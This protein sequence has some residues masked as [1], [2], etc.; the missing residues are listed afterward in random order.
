MKKNEAISNDWDNL[1]EMEKKILQFIADK[2]HCRTS[3]ISR[4]IG[5]ADSTTRKVLNKLKGKQ[6]IDWIGTSEYDP[7]KVYK[8]KA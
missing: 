3:E 2:G 1:S 4:Y 6:L 5:R 8:I 7:K